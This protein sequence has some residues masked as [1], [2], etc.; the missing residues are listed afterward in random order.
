MRVCRCEAAETDRASRHM[1]TILLSNTC[2]NPLKTKRY[3]IG[4]NCGCC[5]EEREEVTA[6]EGTQNR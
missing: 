2:Q 6:N 1:G 3:R 5:V 4:T